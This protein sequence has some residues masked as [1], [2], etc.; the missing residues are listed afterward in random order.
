MMMQPLYR[1]AAQGQSQIPRQPQAHPTRILIK[2][3]SGSNIQREI[4]RV[5]SADRAKTLALK[6]PSQGMQSASA[7]QAL[8]ANHIISLRLLTPNVSLS[9]TGIERILV[10]EVADSALVEET[11]TYLQSR[12]DVEYAEP[13]FIG[14]GAGQEVCSPVETL[15]DTN[16]PMRIGQVQT[17]PNEAYFIYQW[18]MRNTG[19]IIGNRAGT[20]NADANITA[21]WDITTGDSLLTLA[22]IDTGILQDAASLPDFVGRVVPGYDF[23]NN[24]ADPTDDYGH[25]SNVTSIAAAA[26]N[27]HFGVAGVNWRCRV[28]PIKG[29]DKN[30]SGFYSW[31]IASLQFAA[32]NG[33][34]VINMSM[35]G[36]SRSQALEDAVLYARSRGAVVVACMMNTNSAT[37][38]YP[39]GFESVIA[40]GATNNQDLRAMP[41]CYSATSGSNYGEHIDF[42]AP[43]EMIAGL[44]NTDAAVT[45]WCGTS[46]A[47]PIV[48]GLISL[49]LT[50]NPRLSW[51]QIYDALKIGARDGIGGAEDTFG[52]D[53]YF[54]W[55]RV[56]A[57]RTLQ[58]VMTM[59]G[60]HTTNEGEPTLRVSPQPA[61]DEVSI[62][63]DMSAIPKET[64]HVQISVCDMLGRTVLS[65]SQP[66]Q[67]SQTQKTVVSLAHL[68]TG[69]YMLRLMGGTTFQTQMIQVVR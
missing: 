66:V 21:A 35:G 11:I 12:E 41:F 60:V 57:A 63:Y 44:R 15:D 36:T 62:E 64:D 37:T 65:L 4:H 54:G 20:I 28:M 67:P 5:T 14:S 51:Q 32:D 40:I 2:I 29:L 47:T 46:Q 31:W 18:G 53:R 3:K 58:A 69:V 61:L 68:P 52:W 16:K 39:A 22:I 10:A 23:A 24:D 9:T 48:S 45:Y 25:G 38:Y 30:N 7:L 8:F 59:S 42:V 27:N 1:C 49:M 19:Q 50:V 17:L 33:A 6:A 13:D 26:G 43:G 34:K 55:G 56:D